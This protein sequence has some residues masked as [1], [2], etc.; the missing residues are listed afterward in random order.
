METPSPDGPGALERGLMRL[1]V[2]AFVAVTLM[3]ALG[4]SSL[5][6]SGPPGLF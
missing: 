6:L 2:V 4:I 3:L 1:Y 5:L